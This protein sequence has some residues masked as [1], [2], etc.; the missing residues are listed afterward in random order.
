MPFISRKRLNLL[1]Q[2]IDELVKIIKDDELKTLRL[3]S[4]ELKNVKELLKPIKF[5]VQTIRQ[6]VDTDTG[7]EHI[8]IVYDLPVVDLEFQ[9]GKQLN[10]SELLRS[11][12][13]LNFT[14]LED[15]MKIKSEISKAIERSKND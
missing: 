14:G 4:K 15:Q 12:N 13:M 1:Q 2:S 8:Q 3:E 7:A 9:D 10:R 11:V 5:K 6:Y